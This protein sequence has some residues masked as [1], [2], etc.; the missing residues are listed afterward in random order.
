MLS[1]ISV[2]F[3]I[4]IIYVVKILNEIRSIAV[5]IKGE[6][7]KIAGDIEG[8]RQKVRGGAAYISGLLA[9]LSGFIGKR[10]PKKRRK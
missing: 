10:A 1:A 6:A 7:E 8:A 2:A 9:L 5:F 3:I 4:A